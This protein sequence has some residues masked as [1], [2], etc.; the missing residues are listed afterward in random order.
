M[1]YG[2]DVVRY[3]TVVWSIQYRLIPLLYQ[4]VPLFFRIYFELNRYG[5]IAIKIYGST[6]TTSTRYCIECA[7]YAR[8]TKRCIDN[9]G[10][11]RR[12]RNL[13]LSTHELSVAGPTEAT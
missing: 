7:R 3:G 13:Y 11:V 12:R 10:V 9:F 4:T 8:D 1:L 5:R 6:S 2:I